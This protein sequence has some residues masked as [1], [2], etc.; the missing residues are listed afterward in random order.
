M[1]HA[2]DVVEHKDKF[3][4]VADTLSPWVIRSERKSYQFSRTFTLPETANPD[5]ITASMDKGVLTVSIGKRP[6]PAKPEPKRIP[7]NA[8]LNPEPKTT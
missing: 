4:L 3:E 1:P 2:F 7:V 6:E 5:A 8:S